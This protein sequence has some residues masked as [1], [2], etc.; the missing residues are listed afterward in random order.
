MPDPRTDEQVVAE[1]IRRRLLEM[2]E[3]RATSARPVSEFAA[4]AVEALRDEGRLTTVGPIAVPRP[5][6]KPPQDTVHDH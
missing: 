3:G 1:A 2:R 6:R 4:A 5:A